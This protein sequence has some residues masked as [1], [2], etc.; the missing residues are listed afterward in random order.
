MAK[1]WYCVLGW[2]QKI[3]SPNDIKILAIFLS[4]E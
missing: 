1:I 3:R 4:I 2:L